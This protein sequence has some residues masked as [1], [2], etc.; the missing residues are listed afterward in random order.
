MEHF[1]EAEHVIMLRDTMRRFVEKEMPRELAQ[2]WDR[3]NEY[4][5]EIFE[6]LSALG[7]N[8]LTV[9]EEYGGAIH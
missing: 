3:E 6:Q 1:Q 7:V 4:P 8:A 2:K 9:P 5:R